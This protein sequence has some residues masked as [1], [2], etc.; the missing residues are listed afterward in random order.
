M[1][2]FP[3]GAS[4]DR[5]QEQWCE[6]CRNWR[7]RDNTVEACPIM[8]AHQWYASPDGEGRAILNL[9]IPEVKSKPQQCSMFEPK[10]GAP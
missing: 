7:N 5:Y 2:Y 4:G 10:D 9:L 3:N 6:R 1:A 8:D